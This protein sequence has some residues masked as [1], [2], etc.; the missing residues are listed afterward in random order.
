MI[1][2]EGGEEVT[3]QERKEQ[4][5]GK[6]IQSTTDKGGGKDLIRKD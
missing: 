2:G 1:K 5:R 4:M 6:Y 3:L